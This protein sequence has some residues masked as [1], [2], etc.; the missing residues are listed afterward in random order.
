MKAFKLILAAT[1]AAATLLL[2]GCGKQDAPAPAA[3]AAKASEPVSIEKIAA[4]GTGFTVG[5][6]M[7]VKTVY[8]FFDAQCPHCGALWYFAKPIKSVKFVWMPVRFLNDTS[9]SQGATLLASKDPVAAMD[10]H[11]A[12]MTE[13]KGGITAA[14]NVDAQVA[15]VKKNTALMTSY[16]FASIPTI[17]AKNAEGKVV[18]H[19]GALPTAELA[20]FIGVPAPTAQ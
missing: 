6:P 1:I 20:A 8:V 5:S 19:E 3:E 9:L 11:E 18:T 14:S 7:S 2:A 12:S 15:A 13:K 17:I 16:G 4:E 10:E